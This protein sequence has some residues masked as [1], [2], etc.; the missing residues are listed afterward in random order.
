MRDNSLVERDLKVGDIYRI[1]VGSVFHVF[2]TGKA[3]RLWLI[4]ILDRNSD[5][6]IGHMMER[7]QSQVRIS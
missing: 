7:N 6:K 2:N 3:E 4:G 1:H 5:R